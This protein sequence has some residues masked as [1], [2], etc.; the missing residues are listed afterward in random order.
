MSLDFPK[1]LPLIVK[2][3]L[4]VLP[5]S[6]LPLTVQV[7]GLKDALDAGL[8]HNRYVGVI[9]PQK[10]CPKNKALHKIGSLGRIRTFS[11]LENGHYLVSIDGLCR[12]HIDSFLPTRKGVRWA[13]V[14]YGSFLEDW[15]HP[16]EM[17]EDTR[18]NLMDTLAQYMEHKGL[19]GNW[20]D[21]QGTSDNILTTSLTMMCAFDG[22][23]KQA[24]LEASGLKERVQ[25]LT[26]FLEKA[27]TFH[28]SMW[29]CH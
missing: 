22:E 3:G 8:S 14:S 10:N 13:N 4:L 28:D 1:K 15:N 2:E 9:Q 20:E 25:L 26:V 7:P 18:K 16:E 27:N 11:E 5:Q 23:E 24:V 17:P 21:I 29:R 19:Q 6:V 12:F